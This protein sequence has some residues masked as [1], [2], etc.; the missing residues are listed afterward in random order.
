MTIQNL[1]L[2]KSHIQRALPYAGGSTREKWDNQMVKLSSN[3]N[4]LGPSPKAIEAIRKNVYTLHEYRFEHDGQLREALEKSIGLPQEQFVTGNSAMELLDLICR[5]FTDE[6]SEVIISSPTFMAYKSFADVSGAKVIDVPLRD[7][8]NGFMLDVDGI[9]AAVTD[10]TRLLFISNPNNPTGSLI[11][12]ATMDKLLDGLPGRVLVVYDE[13]YHHY[14]EAADYP[15]AVDYI[16]QGRNLIGLHSFSKAYGLAGIRLGYALAPSSVAD[17]LHHL[18]RPFMIGTLATVAGMAALDDTAHIWE[19]QKL[20]SVE[21]RWLYGQLDE[22]GVEY[23]RS[24]A[25]FIL[26]RSPL[27]MG[28]LVEGMMLQNVMIRSAEPMRAPGCVRVTIGTRVANE[29]FIMGLGKV[30]DR[31]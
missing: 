4:G 1:L 15:R 10:H 16:R 6:Q 8:D 19:T 28:K 14:V 18:R 9:L 12:R 26:L 27:P 2:F 29:R 23:W 22:L 30:L 5:G 11:S 13:V 21:R 20:V 3:E 24:E 7:L 17:Y 25:N 31:N